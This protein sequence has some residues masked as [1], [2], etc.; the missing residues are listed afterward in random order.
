MKGRPPDPNRARRGTGHRPEA[1]KAPAVVPIAPARAELVEAE[2]PE[3]LPTDV[4]EVWR[5]CVAEMAGN[6]HLRPPDLVLLRAYCEA[7]HLHAAASAQIHAAGVL[8]VG[9]MGGPMA[10]PLIRVQKD[11][12]TTMR[13]LSEILGLNPLAR[14]RA[15]LMEVAGQSMALELRDRLLAKLPKKGA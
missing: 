12:A 2:P 9:P 6:R 4:A 13:Q 14:I 7:V 3:D 10:N 15:G 1:G 5:A 11:A 8:V